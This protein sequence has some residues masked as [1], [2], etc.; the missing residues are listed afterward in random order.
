MEAHVGHAGIV[1]RIAGAA[2]AAASFEELGGLV[3]EELGAVM[4]IER[5]NIGLIDLDEYVFTDAYVVGRNV[6]GRSVGHRRTLDGTVVEAGMRAGGGIVIGGDPPERL[7]ER[8]PRLRSTLDTG[9]RSML[10]T[11]IECEGR[12]AAALV[13]ASTRPSAYTAEDLRLAREAGEVIRERVM[14]LRYVQRG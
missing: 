8:F 4:P 14:A 3:A 10:A 7:A 1:E 5:M 11:A 9:I 13:L 12:A 6:P 2:G